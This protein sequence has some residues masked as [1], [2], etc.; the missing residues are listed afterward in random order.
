MY[1]RWIKELNEKI[2]GLSK[3]NNRLLKEIETL[4]ETNRSIKAD[5]NKLGKENTQL[6]S[7]I[8]DLESEVERKNPIIS[9]LEYLRFGVSIYGYYDLGVPHSHHMLNCPRNPD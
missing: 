9:Q 1:V 8:S 5:V 7:R 4:K 6:R 2:D 3:E